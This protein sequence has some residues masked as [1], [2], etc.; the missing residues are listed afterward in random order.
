MRERVRKGLDELSY[1]VGVP[2][3]GRFQLP[4]APV[5]DHNRFEPE[6]ITEGE[7][8][9]RPYA[10]YRTRSGQQFLVLLPNGDID[11]QIVRG[12]GLS[13]MVGRGV[14]ERSPLFE[15]NQGFNSA[16][17]IA[18]RFGG[19]G[20][21]SSR[22][23]ITTS[24][25]YNQELMAERER[26]VVAIVE[27]FA[28]QWMVTAPPQSLEADRHIVTFDMTITVT[29]GLMTDA[30]VLAQIEQQDWYRSMPDRPA[31]LRHAIEAKLA[32][33]LQ[34]LRRVTRVEYTIDRMRAPDGTVGGGRSILPLGPDLGL[35]V[36]PTSRPPRNPEE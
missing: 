1:S 31:N 19:S 12:R 9:G 34:K 8:S 17:V 4:T 20:Y 27:E 18:N 32:G 36:G 24:W 10:F 25:Q 2:P 29:F 16:H 30:I 35:L 7:K 15:A 33:N 21:E 23:L 3:Y 14:T 26:R 11:T 22:N 13:L 6:S 5:P 28:R